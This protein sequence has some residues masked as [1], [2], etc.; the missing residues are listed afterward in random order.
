MTSPPDSSPLCI[1]CNYPLRGLTSR[2]CPECGREFDP[3]D[4]KTFNAGNALGPSARRLLL[5]IGFPTLILAFL[6]FSGVAA[7]TRWPGELPSFELQDA[8]DTL[9]VFFRESPL[10]SVRGLP[11]PETTYAIAL[12]IAMAAVG[13]WTLRGALRWIV[14]ISRR[15]GKA[16]RDS[17]WRYHVTFLLTLVATL[18]LIGFGWPW[19]ASARLVALSRAVRAGTIPSGSVWLGPSDLRRRPHERA[20]ARCGIMQLRAPSDRAEFLRIAVEEYQGLLELLLEAASRERAPAVAAAEIHLIGLHRDPT[21]AP[22]LLAKLR[23][24]EPQIRSAAADALG[25]IYASSPFGVPSSYNRPLALKDPRMDLTSLLQTIR[26]KDASVTIPYVNASEEV[27]PQT[28]PLPASTRK[29]LLDIMLVGS[30]SDEREAAARALVSWPPEHYQLRVAEWGVWLSSDAKLQL[31][32]S[33]IDEIPPFVHRTGNPVGQFK[34]RIDRI[35]VITKPI[36]HLSA[37]QPLSVD[38]EVLIHKGRPWFAYP[39]PDDFTIEAQSIPLGVFQDPKSGKWEREPEPAL[40]KPLDL[41]LPP[42][43]DDPREGFP[44]M[45]PTH[46]ARNPWPAGVNSF[47]G[48]T[49]L[50]LRWQSVIVSP[51]K[52]PWMQP[53]TVPDD[54]KFSWWSR[55]R[56]VP[57]SWVSNRGESERFLYYDGPTLMPS[58]LDVRSDG[59]SITIEPNEKLSAAGLYIQVKGEQINGFEQY[60]STHSKVP[61]EFTINGSAVEARLQSLLIK[62]GLNIEE[63]DGLIDT[64]RPQFLQTEGRRF[65]TIF[66]DDD[67]DRV[68]PMKITPAPTQRAR[69][70][71][72][73]TE[74]T[75]PATH[76]ALENKP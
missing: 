46:R 24:A 31:V 9:D 19:R 60:V 29:A 68:C 67:Y 13:W 69:V 70:G 56:K 55:L 45:T 15:P 8:R 76:P 32:Q 17:A 7:V 75:D 14:L 44:W 54:P 35:R 41:K 20:I 10:V 43:L 36:I 59:L 27:S 73:L 5:P 23:D 49:S 16:L 63:A 11:W 18:T 42:P 57:S 30:T 53:P 26:P 52:L 48:I 72:L 25:I 37:S 71:I 22:F 38:L 58:P 34:D 62:A 65:L 47:E 74:F 50:G 2:R 12:L 51:E 33:V 40:L 4:P 66:H 21:A 28:I 61:I 1:S 3:S 6:A 64:W 39:R